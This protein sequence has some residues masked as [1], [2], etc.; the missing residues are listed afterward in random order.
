MNPSSLPFLLQLLFLVSYTL[1]IMKIAGVI[2]LLLFIKLA[3]GHGF[4]KVMKTQG[5]IF[6]IQSFR[7]VPRYETGACMH[8]CIHGD[9]VRSHFSLCSSFC[10]TM[11]FAWGSIHIPVQNM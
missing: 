8:V 5:E 1:G 11:L 6:C 9:Q 4:T 7:S 2:T 10:S 3:L